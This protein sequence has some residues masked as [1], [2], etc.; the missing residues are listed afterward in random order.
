MTH[1]PAPVQPAP[2]LSAARQADAASQLAERLTDYGCLCPAS[3]VPRDGFAAVT[4][5]LLAIAAAAEAA[6]NDVSDA[7]ADVAAHLA[8][9]DASLALIAESR[10]GRRR[11]RRWARRRAQLATGGLEGSQ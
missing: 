2:P 7:L 4:H 9:I 11:W 3:T 6:G 5:G 8:D 1:P 10:P